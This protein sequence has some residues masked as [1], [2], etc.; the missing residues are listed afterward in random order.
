MWIT[1]TKLQTAPTSSFAIRTSRSCVASARGSDDAAICAVVIDLAVAVVVDAIADLRAWEDLALAGA[2]DVFAGGLVGDTNL[3]SCAARGVFVGSCG[4]SITRPRI[5]GDTGLLA[6]FV[7]LAIAVIVET[8]AQ[9]VIRCGFSGSL[10]G[11]EFVCVGLCVECADAHTR[12][13]SPDALFVF[14]CACVVAGLDGVGEA[15]FA[16]VVDLAVAIVVKTVADLGRCG[17]DL[18]DTGTPCATATDL[19]T[20]AARAFVAFVVGGCGR[21]GFDITTATSAAAFVD[22]A[23][24][25]V[26]QTIATF[27][28]R[29]LFAATLAPSA[30]LARLN[31]YKTCSDA[32]GIGRARITL[33]RFTILAEAAIVGDTIAIVVESVSADFLNGRDLGLTGAKTPVGTG[34]NAHFT[35]TC[36]NKL[37]V[38]LAFASDGVGITGLFFAFFA[39]DGGAIGNLFVDGSVTI[40]IDAVACFGCGA[41]LGFTSPPFSVFIASLESGSAT[42]LVEGI[43]LIFGD[44]ITRAAFPGLFAIGFASIVCVIDQSVAIIVFSVVAL[45]GGGCGIRALFFDDGVRDTISPQSVGEVVGF[46]GAFSPLATFLLVDL[47]PKTTRNTRAD[48]GTALACKGSTFSCDAV[49]LIALVATIA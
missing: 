38:R 48:Q 19:I 26:I 18:T 24:A 49:A 4:A 33:L 5:T 15:A 1:Q 44:I 35:Q 42:P 47:Q 21:T 11:A 43:A 40:V 31:T 25:I 23:V 17:S 2:K 28:A 27:G 8:V 34:A 10:A 32:L 39:G 41:N 29:A 6:I 12:V 7:D 16:V 36:A 14:G 22:L 3:D 30:I 9:G 20:I 45:F 37:S 46:A 13:A